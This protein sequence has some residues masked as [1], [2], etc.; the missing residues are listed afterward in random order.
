M[1]DI[2]TTATATVRPRENLLATA[3][4]S[5]H[6][7]HLMA[8]VKAAGLADTLDGEGPY[9]VFAPNDKAFDRLARNEL[10]DLLKPESQAR[11]ADILKLHV[12]PGHVAA[13]AS[14]EQ[15]TMLTTLQGE[16]L[17]LDAAHGLRV[18]KARV[19]ERDIQ[20]SNGV[21]HAIDTVL[22]PCVPRRP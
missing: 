6:F 13:A 18:N 5:G 12:V 16:T 14:A 11:L 2:T 20:A 8:A 1:T 17:S 19:V 21:L 22:M 15:P 9:T 10:A 3:H 4:R 7:K